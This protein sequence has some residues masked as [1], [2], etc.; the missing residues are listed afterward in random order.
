LDLALFYL[1]PA[2]ATDSLPSTGG[3]DMHPCIQGSSDKVL[4]FRDLDFPAM[5]VKLDIDIAHG[6]NLL[7]LFPCC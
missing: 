1:H 6:D 4:A 5:G 3:I 7:K 2:F